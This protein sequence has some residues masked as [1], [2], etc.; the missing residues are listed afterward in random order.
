MKPDVSGLGNITL[1][2]SKYL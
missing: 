1:H 2:Y